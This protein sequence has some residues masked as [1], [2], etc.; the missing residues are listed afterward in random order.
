M[1][2]LEGE[3]L[4][5]RITVEADTETYE[6]DLDPDFAKEIQIGDKLI[7]NNLNLLDKRILMPNATSVIAKALVNIKEDPLIKA[8]LLASRVKVVFELAAA[9]HKLDLK[10][11]KI[12]VY[13]DPRKNAFGI[14]LYVEKSLELSFLN[15]LRFQLNCRFSNASYDMLVS[16]DQPKQAIHQEPCKSMISVWFLI[17]NYNPDKSEKMTF[18]F[19]GELNNITTA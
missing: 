13:Y 1:P 16:G 2:T 10:I 18:T 17:G 9:S 15:E 3:A 7:L 5:K 11:Q 8:R 19:D 14:G 4:A 12:S 6:I